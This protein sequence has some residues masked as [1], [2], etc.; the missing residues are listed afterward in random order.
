MHQL[1]VVIATDAHG[2]QC[3]TVIEDYVTLLILTVTES[4]SYQWAT[5]PT[6]NGTLNMYFRG[7]TNIFS[8][9]C[10]SLHPPKLHSAA[11]LIGFCRLLEQLCC[12]SKS[13]QPWSVTIEQRCLTY[14]N[15]GSTLCH[16]CCILLLF[17]DQH[18][19]L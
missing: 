15:W 11:H 18:Q 4:F 9:K 17:I 12:C 8:S 7:F 1:C 16:L 13:D 14:S 6:I 5:F 10:L 3:S 19:R 2:W